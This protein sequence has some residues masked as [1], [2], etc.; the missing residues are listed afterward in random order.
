MH[1]TRCWGVMAVGVRIAFGWGT[2]IVWVLVRRLCKVPGVLYASNLE[3]QN[4]S[5]SILV[6]TPTRL[7]TLLATP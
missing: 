5:F 1:G 4:I 7:A 6:K 3:G 2:G